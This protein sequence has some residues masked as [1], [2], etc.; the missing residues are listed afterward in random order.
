MR[1]ALLGLLLLQQLVLWEVARQSG[2][3]G[4]KTFRQ[5]E[6]IVLV[7]SLFLSLAAPGAIV[8]W[9]I[10]APLK[11]VRLFCQRVRQGNYRERLVLPNESRDSDDENEITVLL[12]DMNW[13]T[14]QIELREQEL[15]KAVQDLQESRRQVQEQN[16]FL[17]FANEELRA[18]QTQLNERTLDLEGALQEMQLMALTDA[19]TALPNRR[20]FFDVL[21]REFAKPICSF[22]PLTLCSL[23]VD[24]F[25][26][27]NDTYGHD[28]GDRVLTE[29]A[30]LIR[31]TVRSTDLAA[32]IGGEEFALLLPNTG[33]Q[34]AA[35]IA[36]RLRS[37]IAEHDFRLAADCV[38]TV[39][40]SIGICTF[41]NCPC[42]YQ[43]KLY[44]YAD[45]AL[46]HSKRCGRNRIS[47]FDPDTRQISKLDCG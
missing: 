19:L 29:L 46:Y 12:R 40:V 25:K 1:V 9:L 15:E 14:R 47:V 5:I 11:R 20:A 41:A 30:N 35:A 45:Q 21:E 22:R 32:R 44:S 6:A 37:A 17:T 28:A 13:M 2:L 27:I 7:S 39:T 26:K 31:K 42:Y 8:H 3:S 43:D 18:T 33:L 24:W 4:D 16:L 38:V 10:G 34:A 36:A 23:D